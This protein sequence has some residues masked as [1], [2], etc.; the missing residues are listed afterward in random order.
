MDVNQLASAGFFFTNRVDVV[1][2]VFCGLED[3][4]WTEGDDTFKDY[5]R[6]SPSCGFVSGVFVGNIPAPS[7]TSQQPS[8][9]NDVCGR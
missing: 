5:M 7:K 9:S 4:H 2:C 1:R 3:G 6:W 8:S